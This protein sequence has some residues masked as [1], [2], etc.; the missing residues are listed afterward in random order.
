LANVGTNLVRAMV[1]I[2]ETAGDD[3]TSE[4]AAGFEGTPELTNKWFRSYRRTL[5]PG[6]SSTSHGHGAPVAIVQ[7]TTGKG[8]A[9]G[10]MKFEL[11][12]TGQWAFFDAG[13]PH[14]L[15][16]VGDTPLELLEIEVRLPR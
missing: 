5:Q 12:E 10:G 3:T 14:T 7:A 11:N 2:N 8:L 13:V 6:E 15:R 1:V 16:N 4:Q 9:E